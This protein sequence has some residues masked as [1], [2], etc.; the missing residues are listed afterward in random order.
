MVVIGTSFNNTKRKQLI[1]IC[2][3]IRIMLNKNIPLN[4]STE[5]LREFCQLHTCSWIEHS[6]EDFD[7]FIKR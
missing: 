7:K 2:K 6:Y 1:S 4:S 3:R 5:A